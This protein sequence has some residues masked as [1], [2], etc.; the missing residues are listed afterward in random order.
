MSYAASG[1][2]IA[3]FFWQTHA[4]SLQQYINTEPLKLVA[5]ACQSLEVSVVASAPLLLLELCQPVIQPYVTCKS[6]MHR[7]AYVCWTFKLGTCANQSAGGSF[8]NS[9][10]VWH[11]QLVHS[12]AQMP[13]ANKGIDKFAVVLIVDLHRPCAGCQKHVTVIACASTPFYSKSAVCNGSCHPQARTNSKVELMQAWHHSCA[14][15]MTTL[16]AYLAWEL[17]VGGISFEHC[18]ADPGSPGGTFWSPHCKLAPC[19]HHHACSAVYCQG[20]MLL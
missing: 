13:F 14:K 4:L 2:V 5:L 6:H 20:Q 3:L 7:S 8:G 17:C 9:W 19:D 1:T 15:C 12:W 10:N 18:H 16:I 11:A